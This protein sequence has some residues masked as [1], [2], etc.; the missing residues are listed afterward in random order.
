MWYMSCE[1]FTVDELWCDNEL[2]HV[3][4]SVKTAVVVQV[5]AKS[6]EDICRK[7]FCLQVFTCWVFSKSSHEK[8]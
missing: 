6:I 2:R 5:L 3:F 4:S 1:H 7:K 8:K